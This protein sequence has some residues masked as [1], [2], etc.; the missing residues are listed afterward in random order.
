[1]NDPAH[2][3][4][5]SALLAVAKGRAH[6]EASDELRK[7][8]AAVRATGKKGSVTV[9]LD[10]LPPK[11]N[12]EVVSVEDTITSNIPKDKR[13]T[14][15]YTDDEGTLYRNDPKQ[16]SMTDDEVHH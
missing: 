4:F 3:E 9:K 10:I 12:Q 2:K 6:D 5:A 14:M 8:V 11:G 15:F 16:Y 1:M 7:V 13:S